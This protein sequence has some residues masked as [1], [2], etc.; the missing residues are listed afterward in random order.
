MLMVDAALTAFSRMLGNIGFSR[1]HG[2]RHERHQGQLAV[3]AVHLLQPLHGFRGRQHGWC[4]R[5]SKIGLAHPQMGEF[6]FAT[7]LL[8]Y[9]E[10]VAQ[11]VDPFYDAGADSHT[12]IMGGVGAGSGQAYYNPGFAR[13]TSGSY[14]PS[15]GEHHSVLV[16]KLERF[17][18]PVCLDARLSGTKRKF[19]TAGR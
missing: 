10:G 18:V 16:T 9:N 3:R 1:Q 2:H 6:M 8:P 5:N 13:G 15:P 4:N 12:S 17:C 14:Q 7:W 11:W 19:Q